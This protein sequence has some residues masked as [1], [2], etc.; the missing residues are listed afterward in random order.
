MNED[1]IYDADRMN[2]SMKALC[3]P[4]CEPGK[5]Q[6]SQHH[7]ECKI[8]N[9]V[10]SAGSSHRMYLLLSLRKSTPPQNRQLVVHY[11]ELKH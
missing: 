11:Y 6:N 7:W 9:D 5:P 2:E 10:G 3:I 4:L 1:N 8:V